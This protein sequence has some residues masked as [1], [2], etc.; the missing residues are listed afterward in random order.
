MKA[1]KS[2]IRRFTSFRVQALNKPGLLKELLDRFDRLQQSPATAE[3]T[4]IKEVNP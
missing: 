3:L 1:V 4:D 2:E